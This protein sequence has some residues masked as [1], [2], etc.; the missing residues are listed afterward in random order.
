MNKRRKFQ[1]KIIRKV[2]KEANE[3]LR[4][5]LFAGRFEVKL[6]NRIDFAEQTFYPIYYP[7]N[8]TIEE[9]DDPQRFWSLYIIELID[10]EEPERNCRFAFRWSKDFEFCD[11]HP[12]DDKAY[13][14][15]RSGG[16]FLLSEAI[17]DFIV[18]SDFW[19][20]WNYLEYARTHWFSGK[21]LEK[22]MEELGPKWK[23]ANTLLEAVPNKFK[24]GPV[25]EKFEEEK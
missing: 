19:K 8:F 15:Y 18:Y 9:A 12:V 20:K 1:K 10:N 25:P 24:L 6:V 7:K 17:N 4:E 14:Y 11:G 22:Q 13:A 2:L 23:D 5:D 16:L 3:D 21:T